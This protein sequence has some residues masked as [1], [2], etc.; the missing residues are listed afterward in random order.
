MFR[1]L[2]VAPL[3]TIGDFGAPRRV[4]QWTSLCRRLSLVTQADWARAEDALDA[5]N[6]PADGAG[7][8]SISMRSSTRRPPHGR[9]P[10]VEAFDRLLKLVERL[11]QQSQRVRK[12]S[13]W[14]GAVKALKA[15]LL[16]HIGVPT[17][18]E[19]AWA[20]GPAWQ[21]NAADHVERIVAGLA[22]LDHDGVAVPYS[23]STLRQVVGTLLDT[24]V[25]R[26]GD[27][28]GAV[29]IADIG[30]AA[31]IDAAHV[32]VVGLNEG[33][34]PL[35]PSTT[36]CSAATFPSR[37]PESSRARARSLRGPSAPGTRSST[38]T[39]QSPPRLARTD[40]RRGGEMYPSPLLAGMP[41][42]IT[43]RTRS[44]CSAAML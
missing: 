29:T 3:Y 31:C 10:T 4:G 38:A 2:A 8:L 36:S 16:D 11:R 23:P 41:Y 21:R 14:E 44:A 1:L 39:P 37:R 18:R 33:V 9:S 20:D 28:A 43:S 30:G 15:I 27:A 7:P 34:L 42:N 13:T 5:S 17:W 6:R 22:E 40:L 32:F 35:R 26:R 24:P 25:R 12:A 19:R